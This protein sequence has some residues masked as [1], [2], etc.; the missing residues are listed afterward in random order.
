MKKDV[1][2]CTKNPGDPALDWLQASISVPHLT[3]YIDQP[4]LLHSISAA[5][6]QIRQLTLQNSKQ[7]T[8][9]SWFFIAN[10]YLMLGRLNLAFEAFCLCEKYIE[11]SDS[12]SLFILH[13]NWIIASANLD[14]HIQAHHSLLQIDRYISRSGSR[15]HSL[16]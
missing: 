9:R 6:K 15:E 13:C 2:Q 7:D 16:E 11:P 5:K 3:T 14:H 1:Y 10:I 4:T 8:A 12:T